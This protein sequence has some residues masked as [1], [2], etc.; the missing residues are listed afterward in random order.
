MKVACT[1][2]R[3]SIHTK[4]IFIQ[5]R[6]YCLLISSYSDYSR[7]IIE[8]L[9]EC[10]NEPDYI[11]D[12]EFTPPAPVMTRWQQKIVALLMDLEML[13]PGIIS[14]VQAGIEYRLFTLHNKLRVIKLLYSLL[15]EW[16]CEISSATNMTIYVYNEEK[17]LY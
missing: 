12:N 8:F 17:K 14:F 6:T 3:V 1:H 13:K 9:L 11:L 10:S 4:Y 15:I 7:C 2:V 5:L 16:I